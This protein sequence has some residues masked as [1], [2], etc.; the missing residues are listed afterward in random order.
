M[1]LRARRME[2]DD[3]ANSR[4]A[5]VLKPGTRKRRREPTPGSELVSDDELKWSAQEE[6]AH[7]KSEEKDLD[8]A[9][10]RKRVRH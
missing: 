10:G 5:P 6:L 3:A 2:E 8:F 4:E 7:K 9:D 1:T